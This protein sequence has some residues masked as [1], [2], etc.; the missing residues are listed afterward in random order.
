MV[1]VI[2]FAAVTWNL[3][4]GKKIGGSGES[5]LEQPGERKPYLQKNRFMA[6]IGIG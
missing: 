1:L 5:G 3:W 4:Q 2:L 6:R